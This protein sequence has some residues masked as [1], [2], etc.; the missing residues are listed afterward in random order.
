MG[1]RNTASEG[2]EKE[3]RRAVGALGKRRFSSGHASPCDACVCF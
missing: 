1:T 2:E 3:A